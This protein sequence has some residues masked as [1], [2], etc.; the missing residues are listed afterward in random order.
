VTSGE[1]APFQVFW[2]QNEDNHNYMI[3]HQVSGTAG[4][5]G[6]YA[7]GGYDDIG[8]E[9]TATTYISNGIYYAI[10]DPQYNSDAFGGGDYVSMVNTEVG[11]FTMVAVNADIDR[12]S[13]LGETGADGDGVKILTTDFDIGT[14][15]VE[16]LPIELVVGTNTWAFENTGN[17]TL[18]Q[19]SNVGITFSDG[20]FQKTAYTRLDNLMLDGGA[21]A[22]IYEVT[23]DY[24]E[25]GF[26]STR[27][28]VNTPSFNGGG[29]E[30]TEPTYYTL[31]GG[32]A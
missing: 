10:N 11:I 18:P 30:T 29:A 8:D 20:T 2:S 13:Y 23:V 4:G 21:A 19:T 17:L 26:S 27:Y 12:V 24:A 22:A 6:V 25:G 5:A 1:L 7:T 14:G 16:R 3:L 9:A 15:T 32:G 31:N 28:G